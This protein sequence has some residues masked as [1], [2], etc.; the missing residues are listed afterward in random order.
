MAIIKSIYDSGKACVK[1]NGQLSS[2][3]DL[4]VG[5][6]QGEALSPIMFSLFINDLENELTGSNCQS[7]QLQMINLFIL[8]HADDT[9]LFSEDPIDLQNMLNVLQE[10]TAK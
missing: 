3:Y 6:M 9:V 5:L 1:L 10:Y 4:H 2:Y 8:L 7:Y